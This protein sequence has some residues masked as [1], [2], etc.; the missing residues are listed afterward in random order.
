MRF[1]PVF[2]SAPMVR[3]TLNGTRTQAR[4]VVT[5]TGSA[6]AA[7]FRSKPGKRLSESVNLYREPE[8]AL[9]LSP[10][11]IGDQL[12]VK[13]GWG[14]APGGLTHSD[15]KIAYRADYPDEAP[16]TETLGQ[17]RRWE[18]PSQMGRKISRLH[19]TIT[20]IRLERLM[21]IS[22]EDMRA[23]GCLPPDM[24]GGNLKNLR[25]TYFKPFWTSL[26]AWTFGYA[27][28]F[29]PWVWVL[30]F[31]ITK[32]EIPQRGFKTKMIKPFVPHETLFNETQP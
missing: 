26:H 18:T 17:G 32:P 4:I 19:L 11:A 2:F 15:P 1:H 25:T 30:D 31:K 21:N 29:N 6:R 7:M 22:L 12:W 28:D 23:E 14:Y 13:E 10:Y 5:Y 20:G 27:W 16:V 8:K 24:L 9:K 3:A